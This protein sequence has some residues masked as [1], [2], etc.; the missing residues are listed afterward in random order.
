MLMEKEIILCIGKIFSENNFVSLLVYFQT[1][2]C[3]LIWVLF[4]LK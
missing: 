4:A 2:L 1:K 3:N